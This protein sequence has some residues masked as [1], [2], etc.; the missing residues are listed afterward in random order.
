M[1]FHGIYKSFVIT[2]VWPLSRTVTHGTIH[3]W[4]EETAAVFL[5]NVTMFGGVSPPLPELC[6]SIYCLIKRDIS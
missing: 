3:L 1:I 4:D 2:M 6:I 5:D